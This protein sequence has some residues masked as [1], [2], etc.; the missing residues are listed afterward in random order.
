MDHETTVFNSIRQAQRD[1]DNG[2]LFTAH[3]EKKDDSYYRLLSIGEEMA[4]LIHRF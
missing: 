3:I 4:R 2:I 1:K